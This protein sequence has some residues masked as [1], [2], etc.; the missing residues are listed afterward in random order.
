MRLLALSLCHASVLLVATPL[1]EAQIQPQARYEGDLRPVVACDYESLTVI[2]DGDRR[3]TRDLRYDVRPGPGFADGFVEI[4]DIKADLDPL[5]NASEK[6]RTSPSAVRF[7]YEADLV[8]DRSLSDCYVLLTFVAEGSIG[9][10]LEWVGHL[11]AGDPRH[12]KIELPSPAGAVGTLHVFQDGVEVRTNQH[13]A[14]YDIHAYYASLVK[15]VS[16]A[17]AAELLKFDRVYPHVLTRDGRYLATIREQDAKQMLI[18]YDL[19]TMKLLCE[20]RIAD[21]ESYAADLT[22]VSDHEVAYVAADDRENYPGEIRLHL[23]DARTGK[24]QLLRREIRGIVEAVRDHPE[25]LVV[26]DN[27]RGDSFYKY[28][29]R[30]GKVFD[31]EDPSA[32]NYLFDRDGFARICGSMSGN[33]YIYSVRQT[34]T[35]G[36]KDLDDVVKQPNL[37]FNLDGPGWLDR[38]LDVESVGPDGDTLYISTRLGTDTF[39]LAEFSLSQGVIKRTIARLKAYDIDSNDNGVARLLF[40]SPTRRLVGM[41]FEGDKPEVAWIDAGFAKVQKMMDAAFPDHVNYP[42]DWSDDR[43]TFIYFS[44]SDQDPGTYYAFRPGKPELIPLLELGSRLTHKTMAKTV[45]MRIPA[46]DGHPIPVYVTRPSGVAGKPVPLVVRIHGGP[47]ARDHWGFDPVNQFLASRGYEVLQVNYRG[48]SG[49][50]AAFQRAGLEAR[51]DTVVIDDIAD[52]VRHLVSSGEVDPKRIAV[53]GASFGGWAT[54]I[55]L[56]RYPDLYR[57]GIAIS[58]VTDWRRTAQDDRWTFNNQIGATF[59]KALINRP[60]N[61][62][63]EHAIEPYLRAGEIKQPVFIIHGEQDRVVDAYQAQ[64][65]LND[66]KKTNPDV[67]AR[68]FVHASHTYWS[69]SDLV[70]QLNDIAMF[71]DRWM[72]PASPGTVA[73]SVDQPPKKIQN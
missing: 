46:R 1:L 21:T 50:G 32:G 16:E 55:S 15:N 33:K 35:S 6:E 27:H 45:P 19:A 34:P 42:I 66:L 54:Y 7:R 13:P 63:N 58:A 5:R 31:F 3:H 23:L 30:T 17:S 41:V 72:K 12:V 39:A 37:H 52:C 68:S 53:M 65:M 71:L 22:W 70:D 62:A 40:D 25:V 67:E 36:W 20:T 59:W 8:A 11:R 60:D 24:T 26:V 2:K 18:V 4:K 61:T 56:A 48:S 9:T 69:F 73:K 28:N 29:V 64:V 10:H 49:Y 51:L 38:S 57:C 43:S 14:T 47:T 44:A